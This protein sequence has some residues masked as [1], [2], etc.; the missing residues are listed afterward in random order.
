[1]NILYYE[2]IILKLNQHINSLQ[3]GIIVNLPYD[4]INLTF[5]IF[6]ILVNEFNECTE[7]KK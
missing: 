7:F 1:M 5:C 4:N 2:L 6:T 3:I